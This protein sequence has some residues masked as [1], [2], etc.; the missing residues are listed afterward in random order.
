VDRY[1]ASEPLSAAAPEVVSELI[2]IWRNRLFDISWFMRCLNE[3]LA[4]RANQEDQCRGRFWEDRFKSQALLDE[5]ALLTCMSY[6]DFNPIRAGI[7]DTP[8]ESDFTSIQERI[9]AWQGMR[10]TSKKQ[11]ISK[12]SL[13]H[14]AGYS[15]SHADSGIEFSLED[16]LELVDW[17]G[18]AIRDDKKGSV[19][20]E[21]LPILRRLGVETETWLTSIKYYNR[22]YYSVLGALDRIKTFAQAQG[23]ACCRGQEVARRTYRVASA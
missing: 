6:V 13:R 8:E 16:Y 11:N 7:A 4:Q 17:T 10:S 22:D 23:R 21:L 14:F 20:N 12:T 3:H 18:R 15:N 1:L 9:R 5:T 19:P 2:E